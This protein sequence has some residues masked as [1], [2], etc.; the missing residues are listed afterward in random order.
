MTSDLPELR[1]SHADRDRAVETLRI[2]GGDGRLTAEELED[3]LETALSA[4]TVAELAALT[5]DLPAG[6]AAKDL[7]VVKQHGSR[8]I[9]TGRWVVPKR[10]ELRTQLCQ[11]TLD[12][13]EAV[14]SPGTLRIDVQMVH[15]KLVIVTAPGVEI[16]ADGLTL[17]YSKCK[18]RPARA[19]ADPR[20]R[21]ELA[22]TLLHAKVIERWPRRGAAG[23]AG[24]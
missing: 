6:T 23:Q 13:G 2:A 16:D 21:I 17:T 8:Y 18:L 11:V 20:L 1:A 24:I 12:F 19:G 14:F 7:L 4:R 5:A 9:R 15:G 10:I 3:R 22:G